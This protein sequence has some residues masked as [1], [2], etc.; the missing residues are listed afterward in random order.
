MSEPKLGT[1]AL[2][3]LAIL[4]VINSH[5]DI[6]YPIPQLAS[7]GAI[8][9]ALFFMLSA[10][11]I[12]LSE[13]KK[14]QTFSEFMGKRITRVYIPVWSCIL[15][16]AVP[17]VIC[18]V[19]QG[20]HDDV[21]ATLEYFSLH[22]L[23]SAISVLFYPP[24]GFWF[25]EVLMFYYLVGFFLMKHYSRRRL[26]AVAGVTLA[27]YMAMYVSAG[28][29]SILIIEQWIQFK[30]MFYFL[31]FLFGLDLAVSGY[32]MPVR[33]GDWVGTF[34]LLILSLLL[35]H[36]HKLLMMQGML[37]QWQFVQQVLIFPIM[38]TLM[39]LFHQPG[40]LRWLGSLPRLNHLLGLGA[41]MTLELYL[42][43]GPLRGLLAPTLPPF[44]LSVG[45][46]LL[47]VLLYSYGLFRVNGW[48]RRFLIGYMQRIDGKPFRQGA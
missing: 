3:C 29:Y 4:L 19:L 15:L 7:G 36:G 32:G 35:F 48:V 26:W 16:M 27:T 1:N 11:G 33:P 25:L 43:H 34:L 41:A 28:Y 39:R 45:V 17:I 40:V 20:K 46:Y 6:L 44:P 8:G 30:V 42:T 10:Y 2:R 5:M 47:V 23:L 37:L 31:V 18:Y 22:T 13:R 12:N 38:L 24:P 21:K 9:N 14:F